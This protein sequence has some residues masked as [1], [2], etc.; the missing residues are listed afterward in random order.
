MMAAHDKVAPDMV[1][2]NDRLI[3]DNFLHQL[4][5]L[6]SNLAL[7]DRVA[8]NTR[9]FCFSYKDCGQPVDVSV[10]QDASEFL[11]VAFDRLEQGLKR[12]RGEKYLMQNTFQGEKANLMVCGNCGNKRE[13]S[14]D[15]Y[16]LSV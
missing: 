8:Y 15:F 9:D 5:R 13:S 1:E 11:N 12:T 7:T 3:D 4:Q 10:Q 14:E 6:F 16:L 2:Y